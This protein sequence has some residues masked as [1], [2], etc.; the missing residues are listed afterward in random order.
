MNSEDAKLAL[1]ALAEK[2]PTGS[3]VK[4]VKNLRGYQKGQ[5]SISEEMIELSEMEGPFEVI[6][7]LISGHK[8]KKYVYIR[9]KT[10]GLAL[11]DGTILNWDYYFD[12]EW[13]QDGASLK[14]VGGPKLDLAMD[15]KA[16]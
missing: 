15:N 5:L 2:F 7:N 12:P 6:G 16:A 3:T 11:K 1:A 4:F 10:L 14:P 13:V 9:L 8:D